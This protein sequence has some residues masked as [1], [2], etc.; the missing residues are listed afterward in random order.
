MQVIVANPTTKCIVKSNNKFRR[1]VRRTAR[2]RAASKGATLPS[3]DREMSARIQKSAEPEKLAKIKGFE[4]SVM[5][6]CRFAAPNL[7]GLGYRDPRQLSGRKPSILRH[8]VGYCEN[9]AEIWR[10]RS[11]S[12]FT[13]NCRSQTQRNLVWSFITC[14]GQ[15]EAWPSAARDSR[16]LR[17]GCSSLNT[18]WDRLRR[19]QVSGQVLST[20]QVR[21]RQALWFWSV[22]YLE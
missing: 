16:N 3:R 7:K 4:A 6:C 12:C 13:C 10:V 11:R 17:K 19:S 15:I 8:P 5:R 18:L 1:N 21:R 2:M 22:G 14:Q 20:P 9:R